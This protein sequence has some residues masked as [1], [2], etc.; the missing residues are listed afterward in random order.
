MRV[1]NKIPR[2]ADSYFR[3]YVAAP[4]A[5]AGLINFV[6]AADSSLAAQADACT[7]DTR[8]ESSL[9]WQLGRHM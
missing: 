3:V 6:A 5:A 9:V 7:S 4:R 1:K 8:A 2:R